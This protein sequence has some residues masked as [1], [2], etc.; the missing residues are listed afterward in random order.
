MLSGILQISAEACVMWD[1]KKRKRF[2]EL[3]EPNRQL[4]AAEQA[5]VAA[6]VKELDDMEAAYLK[7]ETERLRQENAR[8]AKRNLELA[9]LVKRKEALVERLE[10]IL[11][12]AQAEEHA[13][14][15]ELATVVA[16]GQTSD[17]DD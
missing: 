17:A 12:E 8:L 6:L 4:N 9:E 15:T 10:N 5:E 3:R 11:A 16:S 13:I 7:P 1:D 2:N 14:E